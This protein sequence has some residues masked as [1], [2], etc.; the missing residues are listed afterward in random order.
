MSTPPTRTN[1]DRSCR[2]AAKDWFVINV[3][4]SR[5]FTLAVIIAA[6]ASITTFT[7][8]RGLAMSNN[9][10]GRLQADEIAAEALARR[11]VPVAA[12][13]G[14]HWDFLCRLESAAR[15]AHSNTEAKDLFLAKAFEWASD[16]RNLRCAWD[17]LDAG[18]G[19]APGVDGLTFADVPRQFVWEVLRDQRDRLRAGNY[20]PA[21]VLE[22]RIPKGPDQFRT[23]ELPTVV[24]RTIGKAVLQTIQPFLNPGFDPNSFGSRPGRD[25]RHALARAEA[26]AASGN[27]W[28]LIVQDVK[29][30]FP[31]V[32]RGRLQDIL[33]RKL[34]EDLVQLIMQLADNN[35]TRG[36]PQGQPLGPLLLN[37]YLDHFLDQPWR[38]LHPSIPIIRVPGA[39]LQRR[40][41]IIGGTECNLTSTQWPSTRRSFVATS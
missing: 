21:P 40:R 3:N 39:N 11:D 9:G 10:L 34:P 38:R 19:H 14:N 28:V 25:R 6:A 12:H 26:I 18:G 23:L 20:Q 15:L 32:P 37:V 29:D 36:I 4:K 33:R 35:K 2:P 24:D 7:S 16:E 22:R 41:N 27:R 30:A 31:S 1:P 8:M 5:H 13:E 17:R